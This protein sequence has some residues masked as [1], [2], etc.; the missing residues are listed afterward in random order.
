M[1]SVVL[2]TAPTLLCPANRGSI[3]ASQDDDFCTEIGPEFI[4][5]RSTPTPATTLAP[6]PAP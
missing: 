6:L 4:K 3:R 5:L 1:R 2:P